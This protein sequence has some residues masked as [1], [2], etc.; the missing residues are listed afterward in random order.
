MAIK[1]IEASSLKKNYDVLG[2]FYSLV[3]PN[4]EP[5]PCRN[6]L[7]ITS[8]NA[9]Q[10]LEAD[11]VFV[12][13]NPGSSRPIDVTNHQVDSHHISKM[14]WQFVPTVPDTTQ[15]QI[16]RVMHYA[17]WNKVRVINLSDLRDPKSGSFAKRYLQMEKRT[18]CKSHSV[19]SPERTEELQSH[20]SGKTGRPVI[21]AWGVSD[22]LNPLIERAIHQLTSTSGVT[23]LAKPKSSNKYFHPLPLLQQQKE[24]WVAQLL[25]HLS[26]K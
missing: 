3:V 24:Q 16:M 19:F 26:I 23:G 5:L 21:C 22:D 8:K 9:A 7:Q 17:G 10:S 25:G 1:N 2:N 4:E 12:M 20:L 15:Y 14:T 13:M 18:G 11:V 6:V